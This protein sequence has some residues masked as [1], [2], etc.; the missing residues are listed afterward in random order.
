MQWLVANMWMALAVAAVLGLLFG[1]SVRGLFVGSRVRRAQVERDIART[2]LEQTRA[3]VDALYAAQRKRQEE[4]SQAVVG[5]DSLRS[6]LADREAKISALGND[7]AAAR[8]E[9]E[10]LRRD[11]SEGAAAVASAAAGAVGGAVLAGGDSK[12]LTQLRDRNAWLEERVGTLEA[13]I[14]NGH[15]PAAPVVT[16]A[17]EPAEANA[18]GPATEK[19]EWQNSY[20]RQRVEALESKVLAVADAAPVTPAATDEAPDAVEADGAGDEELA[21]LRWR[22]RYLEG[23]LAYYEGGEAEAEAD[24]EAVSEHAFSETD[25]D[26][27]DTDDASEADSDAEAQDEADDAETDALEE[28]DEDEEA[29]SDDEDEDEDDAEA[30][31][32]ADLEAAD[33]DVHP[34]EAML[35]ELDDLP[36][37]QP[38]RTERPDSGGDDLTAIAGIGPRI[39]EVLN[40]LGIWTYAQIASWTPDNEVWIENHLSFKGRVGREAWVQQAKDLLA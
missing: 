19:L 12:E 3:E 16:A 6:E 11:K 31:D 34:S 22:N 5:D 15:A 30:D 32:E 7:L 40:E 14:S 39:A 21:R 13:E 4:G 33:E 17:A 26:T 27:D 2:E 20:L 35:A 29:L 36:G 24:V 28:A 23:R 9:L 8:S 10:T 18:V 38:E 37:E 1:F 25:E